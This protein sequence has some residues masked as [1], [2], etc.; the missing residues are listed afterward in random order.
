MDELSLRALWPAIAGR[1]GVVLDRR[2]TERIA[3]FT[4]E[5]RIGGRAPLAGGF[6]VV[7]ERS[8]F[9]LRRTT[10]EVPGE[11]VPLAKSLRFGRFRF[12]V[13][14]G[15]SSIREAGGDPWQVVLP[16]DARLA[17]RVWEPGDRMDL[18]T[19]GR[20]RRVKRFF[21]DAGI[22]GPLREGW[23]VVLVNGRIEWIPGVRRSAVRGPSPVGRS[24][25]VRCERA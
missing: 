7:R 4:R 24:V 10:A 21:A 14:S 9:R 12:E 6:E 19:S 16:R 11:E 5:A 2:G 20:R 3:R 15:A 22:A 8:A 25:L 23:P 1:A 13:L 17:V 18:D